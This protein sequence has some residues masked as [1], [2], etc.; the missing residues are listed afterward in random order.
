VTN[1]C[2]FWGSECDV[3]NPCPVHC[4]WREIRPWITNI[5]ERTTLQELVLKQQMVNEVTGKE[6]GPADSPSTPAW[7][8]EQAS[9]SP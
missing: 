9:A 2:F 1:Q 5:L 6:R 8:G 7:I 3:T 4:R